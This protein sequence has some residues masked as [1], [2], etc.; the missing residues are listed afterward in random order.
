MT[1]GRRI[2][3]AIIAAVGVLA[4]AAPTLAQTSTIR[5]PTQS[6]FDLC[7]RE[8]QL[9]RGSISGGGSASP[10]T[11]PGTGGLTTPGATGATSPGATGAAGAT[12]GAGSV[13]G[14]STLSS[15]GAVTGDVQLRGMGASGASDAAYQQAY[16]DCMRRRGF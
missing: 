9:A 2:A 5:T 1:H 13:S 6:D 11:M 15:G 3:T 12:G 7:N 10:S 14:G 4:L 8:A 16:R